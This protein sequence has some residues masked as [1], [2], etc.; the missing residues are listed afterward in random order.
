MGWHSS[1]DSDFDGMLNRKLTNMGWLLEIVRFDT[2]KYMQEYLLK[3]KSNINK[4]PNCPAA[5]RE[6]EIAEAA[7]PVAPSMVSSKSKG[8]GLMKEK[9]FKKPALIEPKKQRSWD[10]PKLMHSAIASARK[11]NSL[12]RKFQS[13]DD[14]DDSTNWAPVECKKQRRMMMLKK[15][16]A[17]KGTSS[18]N[19][20]TPKR[21]E[22]LSSLSSSAH[23]DLPEAFKRKI[24]SL[25]GTKV[26]LVIQKKLRK[27]DLSKSGNRMSMPLNQISS[28]D[29]LEDDERGR[30]E[31][32]ETMKV[33]LIDPGLVQGDINLRRWNMKKMNGKNSKMYVLRTQWSDVAKRN[34]LEEKDLVQVWSFRV[35]GA[36]YLAL[37]LVNESCGGDQKESDDGAYKSS[38]VDGETSSGGG[39][40]GGAEVIEERRDGNSIGESSVTNGS[41]HTISPSHSE[42]GIKHEQA[43]HMEDRR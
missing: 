41:N 23:H 10:G 9:A 16:N 21:K 13:R 38:V 20:I 34:H 29:F 30:L 25:G 3:Q 36:L 17:N 12:K 11:T 26:A 22:E 5:E 19:K 2:E 31:K 28:T 35:N 6:S 27:T 37:V 24:D 15:K 4:E 39:S 1:S 8:E 43:A 42:S 7:H 33:Q 14:D 40:H 32:E 18:I